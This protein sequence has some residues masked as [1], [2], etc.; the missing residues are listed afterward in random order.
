[1][2]IAGLLLLSC[3]AGQSTV[4]MDYPDQQ[5]S[6]FQTFARQCSQC[7]APPMPTVHTAAEWPS[8]IARMQQHRVQRS[9]APILAKDMTMIRDYLIQHAKKDERT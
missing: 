3:E 5:S 8:V 1:M 9:L 6:A 7:H 4:S 2:F